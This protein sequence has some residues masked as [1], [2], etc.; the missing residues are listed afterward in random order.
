MPLQA[1]RTPSYTPSSP[2]LHDRSPVGYLELYAANKHTFLTG[3]NWTNSSVIAV[4]DLGVK[5]ARFGRVEDRAG[6]AVNPAAAFMYVRTQGSKHFRRVGS[7]V[8]LRPDDLVII[9]A[10]IADSVQKQHTLKLHIYNRKVATM[11]RSA[12]PTPKFARVGDKCIACHAG[13]ESSTGVPWRC[14]CKA[15]FGAKAAIPSGGEDHVYKLLPKDISFS[16]RLHWLV[17]KAEWRSSQEIK[18]KGAERIYITG[19]ASNRSRILKKVHGFSSFINVGKET[20]CFS[21]DTIKIE[22]RGAETNGKSSLFVHIISSRQSNTGSSLQ[23]FNTLGDGTRLS[24]GFMLNHDGS[25]C[26][27]C[28]T[29]YKSAENRDNPCVRVHPK[30]EPVCPYGKHFEEHALACKPNVCT[31]HGGSVA[32]ENQ[33][34]QHGSVMCTSCNPGF[35]MNDESRCI[36]NVCHC[37]EGQPATGSSCLV[38]GDQSCANCSTTGY[39]LKGNRCIPWS[40]PCSSEEIESQAPTNFQDRVCKKN[41]CDIKPCT[42]Q[43]SPCDANALCEG[44]PSNCSSYSCH[45]KRG[46]VGDGKKCE[47]HHSSTCDVHPCLEGPY[48]CDAHAKCIE[49]KLPKGCG[50][51]N[52]HCIPP[53]FGNGNTCKFLSIELEGKK[54]PLLSADERSPS[55]T[56]T[57]DIHPCMNDPCDSHAECEESDRS[58]SCGSYSCRCIT[59]FYGDGNTCK[60]LPSERRST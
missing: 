28:E 12:C 30:E 29:E 48:P 26:E 39:F 24:N 25:H 22:I 4:K 44:N 60:M 42:R 5:D 27:L 31:C 32:Y 52:C 41:V 7:S 46:W 40:A 56:T 45:C 57:C 53:Y 17:P 3:S 14:I 2:Q 34:A 43:P 18:I 59:P 37:P 51:Y 33:C 20:H 47:L 35:F 49:S 13:S 9:S 10:N 16:K 11:E 15:G 55:T 19:I 50:S 1:Q 8:L 23:Y 38:N 54:I 58:E 6:F 36:A 21:G